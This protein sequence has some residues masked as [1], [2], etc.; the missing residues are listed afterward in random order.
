M[1]YVVS[2]SMKHTI[3]YVVSK[4]HTLISIDMKGTHNEYIAK[5]LRL[6]SWPLFW[7]S[8]HPPF[9][10]GAIQHTKKRPKLHFNETQIF[11]D[12]FT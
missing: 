5:F 2:S 1:I 11:G 6:K 12:I 8:F 3:L 9:L 4:L 10:I 7:Q